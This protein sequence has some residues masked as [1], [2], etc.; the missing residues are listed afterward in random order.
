M[1]RPGQVPQGRRQRRPVRTDWDI[2]AQEITLIVRV[3]RAFDTV[4]YRFQKNQLILDTIAL[5]QKTAQEAK[6]LV[7][8][9][10]LRPG[11]LIIL[12]SEIEDARAQ[13]GRAAP[14]WRRRGMICAP[15][16]ASS[17]A[18]RS[19]CR[20]TS[21]APPMP[22]HGQETVP[23]HG[24]QENVPQ[25]EASALATRPV[26]I[27]RTVMPVKQLVAEA[28]ALLRLEVA[29]RMAT[30]GRPHLRVR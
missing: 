9:G 11:D 10:K 23:Q 5:D 1:A 18:G 16:S 20:A 25:N 21:P 22:W 28:D 15:P 7:A 24:G 2:A 6:N 4:V 17:A 19:T 8:A 27:G 14:R 30:D 26:N 13:L 3:I 12:R 29:N